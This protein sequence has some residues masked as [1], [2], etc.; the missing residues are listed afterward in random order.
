MQPAVILSQKEILKLRKLVAA[1]VGVVARL[2]GQPAPAPKPRKT[3]AASASE[4]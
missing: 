2:E 1:F 4:P 3:K